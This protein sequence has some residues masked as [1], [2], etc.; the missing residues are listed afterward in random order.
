MK[1]SILAISCCVLVLTSCKEKAPVINFG[2]PI[3]VDTTFVISPVPATEPHNVL[4]EEFTGQSCSNCPSAHA[5]LDDIEKAHDGRV[6]V[7]GLYFEGIAQTKPPTGAKYDFRHDHAKLITSLYG[8]VNTIPA[9]GI[10]RVP[11]S[12]SLKIDRLTW[13][14]TI[15]SRL[16]VETPIN[17]KVE[18]DY[19]AST[20][21]A[22]IRATLVYTKQ[23][24]FPHN[25]SI[26]IV[27]DSM[28]DVQEYPSTDPVHPGKD[29]EYV[30]TNVFRGLVTSP[31]VGDPV[32]DSIT[33][34]EP[35]RV[36][37]RNFKYKVVNVLTPAR[38]RVIAFVNS[39]K[40]ND[41]T[42]IQSAQVRMKK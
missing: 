35:G 11:A 28:V 21:E 1:K 38:C 12:G 14:S 32:L 22:S 25:L 42:I 17:L 37:V 7:I 16:A 23:V 30:F 9:G 34:K 10:D 41:L 29:D 33:T 26:A 36:F 13:T 19:D 20:N 2:Q 24:D 31:V 8:G 39:T 18:S 40:P 3:L 27:E 6:N 4:V 15:N 5:T